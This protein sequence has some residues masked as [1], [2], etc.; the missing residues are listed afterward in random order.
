VATVL[1]TGARA[2]V[3][4]EIARSFRALGHRVFMADSLHWPL[5]RWSNSIE[6][7]HRIPSPVHD[8]H[9]FY[10]ALNS[11][12]LKEKIDHLIP[13]CEETFYISSYENFP[14][15]CKVWTS[16]I[17]LLEIL[18]HKYKFIQLAADH[19]VVPKTTSCEHFQDWKNA[20]EYVFKPV[21]SRFA[22][23]TIIRKKEKYCNAPK[24]APA[25]W[26]AQEYIA[27]KEICVYSIWDHGV[28]KAYSCYHSPYR[29]GKGAGIL[30]EPY[31]HEPAFKAVKKI[32]EA[33]Q[34]TGQL[35]FD[36][37]I[38]NDQPYV[39]ECNPRATSG[40]HLLNASL[41]EAFMDT[42][43][44]LT[45]PARTFLL[46]VPVLLTNPLAV[47]NKKF[48]SSKDVIFHYNDWKPALL[49]PASLVELFYKKL[50]YKITLLQATTED[51]EWNGQ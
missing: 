38:K 18:H 50:K 43:F 47:F 37:I 40:A 31:E 41:G 25:K 2:P 27:G 7:Y 48:Y 16:G 33:I 28:L 24:A 10:A 13:T 9:G 20:E 8:L 44:I 35:S 4:L 46:R 32:G 22:S 45:K 23:S 36:I 14:K 11:I 49:Q 19:F 12:I 21:Y 30:F 15:H 42:K 17:S 26:I 5:A 3:A 39:L 6:H 1:L 51:I 34:Y 29:A